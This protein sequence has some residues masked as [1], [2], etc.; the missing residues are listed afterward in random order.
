MDKDI[1]SSNFNNLLIDKKIG[2][3]E[4]SERTGIRPEKLS[5]FKN[6]ENSVHPSVDDLMKIS[7]FFNIS[8][9]ELIGHF[10]QENPQSIMLNF[11]YNIIKL[12]PY[13]DIDVSCQK[14][15]CSLRCKLDMGLKE[16]DVYSLTPHPLTGTKY[17]AM[18]IDIIATTFA[19]WLKIKKE[20]PDLKDVWLADRLKK[21]D[22][23]YHFDEKPNKSK[24]KD[25]K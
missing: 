20:F 2:L 19:E 17:E 7:E 14:Y 6:P 21:L 25:S 3:K 11:I 8:I 23:L 1:F 9:D 24:T 16:Y 10:K 13:V 12:D 22:T 18:Y 15:E 4:L 5:K